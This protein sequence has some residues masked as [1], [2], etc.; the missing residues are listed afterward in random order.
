MKKIYLLLLAILQLTTS[1]SQVGIGTASPNSNALLDLTSTAK[2][3]LLPRLTTAQRDAIAS[4]TEG[5]VIYNTTAS[6][7]E[8]Y[9]KSR[10]GERA[11]LS[12]TA[13]ASTTGATSMWQEFTPTV[14]GFVTKITLT[15]NAA[16]AEFAMKI[17]SGVTSTNLSVLNGGKVIGY[18]SLYIPSS[19]SGLVNY[20]YIFSSP[21][22][23]EANTKYWFQITTLSG[24][25]ASIMLN[26]GSD[27]YP[28]HNSY[29]GGHN[30]EPN[31]I[32]SL[33][34]IGEA[35]WITIK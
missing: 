28:G 31:F 6:A 14:S 11:M 15:Q 2:G 26:F 1:W 34:P 25:A 21:V 4:P 10:K 19:A 17:H 22:F 27:V 23:V 16:G 24:S 33:Q 20:D 29:V 3:L 32:L 12:F 13:G 7:I 30:Y 9:S 18:T 8:V 35:T 5:L